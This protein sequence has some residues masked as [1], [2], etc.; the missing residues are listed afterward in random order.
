MSRSFATTP[1]RQLKED[2][3]RSGEEIEAKKR[4]Q[5]KKQDRGDGHWHEELGSQ[6]ESHVKADRE[7]I[8]DH[9]EHI[10]DLQDQTEKAGK[11]GKI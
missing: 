9:D 7:N 1:F 10:E 4:E 8:D 6:S 2:A 3:Q 11:E 5:L